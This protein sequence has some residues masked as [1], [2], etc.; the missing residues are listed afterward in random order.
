MSKAD[1]VYTESEAK[2]KE[3]EELSSLATEYREKSE[4]GEKRIEELSEELAVSKKDKADENKR[5]N[6]SLC[7]EKKERKELL[8]DK[9]KTLEKEY[10]HVKLK[11]KLD[12]NEN[13]NNNLFKNV[14]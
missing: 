3:I 5:H 2:S 11:Y 8:R 6:E 13:G 12:G 9:K 14:E 1:Q 10:K 7:S 4:R